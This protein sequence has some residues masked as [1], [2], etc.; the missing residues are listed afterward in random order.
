MQR[1]IQVPWLFEARCP[2][3]NRILAEMTP[4]DFMIR[5]QRCSKWIVR[6]VAYDTREEALKNIFKKELTTE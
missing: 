4:C 5:C 2:H 6:D 3:C 1:S